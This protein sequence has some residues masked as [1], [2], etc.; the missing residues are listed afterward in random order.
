MPISGGGGGLKSPGERKMKL[1][2]IKSDRRDFNWFKT[3][4]EIRY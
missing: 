1:T 3:N 4:S 2:E